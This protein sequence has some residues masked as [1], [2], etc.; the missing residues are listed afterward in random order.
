MTLSFSTKVVT[1]DESWCYGYN[2]EL[3]QQSNS[4]N[5]QI[6]PDQASAASSPKCQDNVDFI[7]LM[8]M[9]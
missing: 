4:R 8:L 1:G 3:K 6:H 5:H 9:G 7:F 2:P